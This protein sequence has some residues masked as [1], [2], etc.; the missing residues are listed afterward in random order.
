MP[1]RRSARAASAI[2]EHTTRGT[3]LP[4]APLA[5]GEGSGP[6]GNTAERN[7]PSRRRRER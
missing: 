3:G 7:G 1:W 6:V 5:A 2:A 4:A